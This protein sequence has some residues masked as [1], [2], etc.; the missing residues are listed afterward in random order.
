MTY[1]SGISNLLTKSSSVDDLG[2]FVFGN[3]TNSNILFILIDLDRLV[4][5]QS[6]ELDRSVRAPERLVLAWARL[7]NNLIR[8]AGIK[9][10][11]RTAIAKSAGV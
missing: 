5:K 1:Q 2:L 3:R 11:T 9:S 6:A 7:L 8:F 10:T 4:I